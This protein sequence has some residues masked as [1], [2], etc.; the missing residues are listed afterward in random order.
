MRSGRLVGAE[1]PVADVA[2]VGVA[3]FL[4]DGEGTLPYVA[5]SA[6]IAGGVQ[7]VTEVGEYGRG[8]AGIGGSEQAECALVAVDGLD[9]FPELVVGVAETA[10]GQCLPE[11]VADVVLGEGLFAERQG[12]FVGAEVSVTPADQAEGAG[13]SGLVAGR[14]EEAQ[15]L[16]GV[17]KCLPV[18]APPRTRGSE[19]DVC[20]CLASVV[21]ERAEQVGG[22]VETGERLVEATQVHVA[23]ARSRWAWA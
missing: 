18:V 20:V 2:G 13:P 23:R 15:R 10:P 8:E 1:D 7:R 9:V 14:L 12:L 17:I 19:A 22:C 11:V 5:C 6:D 4:Q 3:E 21:P 16:L